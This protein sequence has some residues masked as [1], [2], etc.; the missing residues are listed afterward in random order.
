MLHSLEDK[1]PAF[2]RGRVGIALVGLIGFS[3]S[4][5]IAWALRLTEDRGLRQEFERRAEL[6][7]ELLRANLKEYDGALFA[8]RL[9]AEN[10]ES[11]SPDEFAHAA[12]R[13]VSRVGEIQAVQWVPVVDTND[14][15]EFTARMRAVLGTDFTPRERK[16]DNS[17]HP[18]L[19][20]SP[21]GEHAIITYIHPYAGN[22]AA[23]GYDIFTAPSAPTLRQARARPGV[24]GLSAPFP[25]VQGGSGCV[26]CLYLAPSARRDPTS[27]GGCFIQIVLRIDHSFAQL[28]NYSIQP[29]HD[30]LIVDVTDG[31]A[32]PIYH[33]SRQDRPSLL[34]GLTP[35]EFMTP[36]TLVRDLSIGGRLWRVYFRPNETWVAS[37]RTLAPLLSILGGGLLTLVSMAYLHNLGR[38]TRRIRREV[39]LRTA[40]LNENRALLDEIIDHNPSAIWVK[41]TAFRYQLVNLSFAACYNVPRSEILG[42]SDEFLHPPDATRKM[43]S[44]DARIL[45]TGETVSFEGEYQMPAGRRTYLVSK[46]PVRRFDDSICG[47][48][49]IATDITELRD[50]EA[51]QRTIERKLQETQKLESL[52]VL[53]GGV[54]HD[55]NN[56]LT[57][58]LGHANLVRVQLPD[59]HP[60][61]PSIRQIETSSLRAAEL[62]RQMLAY[63]GR[64]RL[65]VRPVELGEL[66][67]DTTALIELSLSR[68]ARLHFDLAPG[69]PLVVADITQIRQIVM[70]LVLNASEAL[71][72]G[73]GD[74]TLRTRALR[75]EASLFAT[76]VFAPELPAGD[77][78]LLEIA[79]TGCGMSR[80]TVTRIFD[81]FFT[82]KFTGRGLGL[83]AVLGIV[84]GHQ[85]AL[86]VES[87]PG[88]G[89]TFRIYFPAAC[90]SAGRAAPVAEN[91]VAS[92]ASLRILLVDDEPA[93]LET[94]TQLL[95]ACGHVVTA[96]ADGETALRAFDS[97]PETFEAAIIDLTMPG[98]GGAELLR[99]LREKKPGLPVLVISGYTEQ[100]GAADRLLASPRVAFLPKPFSLA[101][102]RAKLAELLHPAGPAWPRPSESSD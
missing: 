45:A 92:P 83:A 20:P 98:L 101:A 17:L 35:A 47:V 72:D 77:Y 70:N 43:E 24:F 50:A 27:A 49:G 18:I 42:R 97:A 21:R 64:G 34:P 3:V 51:N 39:E 73:D 89:T 38:Q 88:H 14:L 66:V 67:R 62:C 99:R 37:R 46:F 94:A 4:I 82:T 55:F 16:A 9:L 100:E 40:E 74:I 31:L 85:G 76:C 61:Q 79:D 95:K 8:L 57:G 87:A 13:L 5:A 84:R 15:P 102:L 1:L 41:D 52:G 68:R 71:V 54:A 22:E 28:F 29:I 56:L 36:D 58:I 19:S 7:N 44:L 93:V 86:R 30:T 25:L 2:L 60:L 69:L 96:C 23:L 10:S 53:A 78:V 80:E 48:A 59:D 65:D 91:P 81:P 32:L 12:R 6:R 63:S 11:L 90:P 26:F 33:H 75:A